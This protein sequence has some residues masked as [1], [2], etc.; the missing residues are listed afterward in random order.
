MINHMMLEGGLTLTCLDPCADEDCND[1]DHDTCLLTARG[2]DH[3]LTA[4]DCEELAAKLL[5]AAKI[6]RGEQ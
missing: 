6:L 3:E 4:D 5:E 2:K 1:D